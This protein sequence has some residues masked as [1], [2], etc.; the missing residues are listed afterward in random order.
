MSEKEKLRI[1]SEAYRKLIWIFGGMMCSIPFLL[2]TM[3]VLTVAYLNP[4]KSVTVYTNAYGEA[5]IELIIFSILGCF[6]L[7]STFSLITLL[8]KLEEIE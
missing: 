8:F 1:S 5:A 2:V 4:A 7:I 6:V 3:L